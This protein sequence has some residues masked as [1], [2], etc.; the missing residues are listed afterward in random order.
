MKVHFTCSTNEFEKY[1]DLY[2]LI[3]KTIKDL[4]H[5]LTRDWIYEER[6]ARRKGRKAYSVDVYNKTLH[7]ILDA[8]VAVIEGTVP[9]FHIGHQVTIALQQK[10]P[11]LFLSLKPEKGKWPLIISPTQSSERL[12]L[13][14]IK[15]YTRSSLKTILERFFY[16]FRKGPTTRFNLILDH[17]IE[18]YLNWA[19]FIHKKTKSE[20]IR[21]L[22]RNEIKLKDKKY[23]EHLKRQKKNI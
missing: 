9:S 22:L 4:G 23:R 13:L 6:E 2:E 19:T 7:A 21:D 8:D 12:P 17:E 20:I 1:F 16:D 14:Y 10:K 11:V 15:K 18:N 3:R 5:T